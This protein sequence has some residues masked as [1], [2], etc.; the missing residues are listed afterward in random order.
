MQDR[1]I[2]QDLR[3]DG[4]RYDRDSAVLYFEKDAL[5]PDEMAG[6]ANLVNQGIKDIEKL[7]KVP[8]DQS[9]SAPLTGPGPILYY[10]GSR[11]DIS[12]SRGRMVYLPLWRVQ[13]RAAPYLHETT[14]ILARCDKCPMW[15]SEG[16]ASWVQS[17]ISENV[18]GYDA[19]V[20]VRSGNRGVDDEAARWLGTTNGQAVLPFVMEGGVPPEI[21]TER[22]AVG[23]PFYVLS[24][25]LVKYLVGRAGIEKIGPLSESAD[26]DQDLERAAGDKLVALTNAWLTAIRQPWPPFPASSR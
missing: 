4:V 21:G 10:I 12:R 23:A 2:G 5:S 11:I 16:F 20:F 15:F 18:G 9:R 3:N 8:D 1:E 13:R 17:Y 19:K 14:H 7:L 25:S 6:F 22:R 24:Q 26:F